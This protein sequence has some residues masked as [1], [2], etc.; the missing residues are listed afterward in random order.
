M[1]VARWRV[2]RGGLEGAAWP[3]CGPTAL[4]LG[5]GGIARPNLGVRAPPRP[6]PRAGRSNGAGEDIIGTEVGGVARDGGVE[7]ADD[8]LWVKLAEGE[9]ETFAWHR[10]RAYL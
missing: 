7:T 9:R 1:G 6:P 2:G 5:D 8:E 4:T 10:K 3:G